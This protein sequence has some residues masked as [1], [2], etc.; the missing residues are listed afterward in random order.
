MDPLSVYLSTS[1]AWTLCLSTCPISEAWTLCM[2]TSPLRMH[3]HSGCLPVHFGGSTS[4]ALTLCLSTSPLRRH[5][6]W[7]LCLS[8][9]QLRKPGHS[10]FTCPLRRHRHCV[11]L[12][13]HF[14]GMDALSVYLS[15]F[16]G[17]S[18][19]SVYLSTLEA[20]IF[21][22]S[23]ISPVMGSSRR[24]RLFF[25]VVQAARFAKHILGIL[26]IG[27]SFTK[28]RYLVKL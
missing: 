19:L 20:W 28:Y 14:R 3:G 23:A 2:S 13:V 6:A 9:C 7:T 11:C 26:Y 16:G 15:T 25:P 22:I 5:E 17:M 18:T 8:T 27:F 1:E 24:D 4:E 21:W 10:L 12:P